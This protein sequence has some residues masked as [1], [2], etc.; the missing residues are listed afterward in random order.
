MKITKSRLMQIIREEVELH[1]KNTF[2]ISEEELGEMTDQEEKDALNSEIES[3]EMG[4][5]QEVFD[6]DTED[7]TTQEDQIHDPATKKVIKPK[8]SQIQDDI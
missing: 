6:F 1:E 5:D 4:M 8:K 7:Y 3:D 2:D